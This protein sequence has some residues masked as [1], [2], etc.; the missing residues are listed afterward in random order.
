MAFAAAPA[1]AQSAT[2]LQQNAIYGDEDNTYRLKFIA[3][4][5]EQGLASNR[6]AFTSV[7]GEEILK[8]WVIWN[9]GV[10]RPNGLLTYN[11]PGGDITGE[12]LDA[13]KV[14]EGV[15]YTVD[16]EGLIDL[17]PPGDD[18]AA[19]S[20]LLPDFGRQLRYSAAFDNQHVTS[21][22]WDHFRLAG[23]ANGQ[24]E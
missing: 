11:C 13:C 15:V 2:C 24:A 22:P 3:D 8:G 12:E 19:A 6:F 10:S 7:S 20:I 17:L 18:P 14:W 9:N 21:V 5:G 23:C 4:D 1:A 16:R